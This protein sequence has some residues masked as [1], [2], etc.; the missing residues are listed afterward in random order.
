MRLWRLAAHSSTARAFSGEGAALGGGRWNQ[1]G[2]RVIYTADSLALAVLEV[3]VH[4]QRDAPPL[5]YFSY[6]V[7]LP[8]D[9]IEEV[10]TR[11]LPRGWD[12]LPATDASRSFGSAWVASRRSL[13]L[14][15]P[16]LVVPAQKCLLIN[17]AHPRF[18]ELR[19]A[20]PQRF[21]FDERLGWK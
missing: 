11:R 10:P 9:A 18:S 16:S 12:A 21:R 7:A 13:A 5:R 20:K 3:L 4:F 15:V 8:D 19:V 17:P 6:E 1:L 14:A 2:T